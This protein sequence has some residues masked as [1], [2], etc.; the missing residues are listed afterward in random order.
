MNKKETN[1]ERPYNMVVHGFWERKICYRT[2]KE[3]FTIF[4]L[5]VQNSSSNRIFLRYEHIQTRN[6]KFSMRLV[7]NWYESGNDMYWK[8]N[9]SGCAVLLNIFRRVCSVNFNLRKAEIGFL[10][11][12][13][14][15][16]LCFL[17]KKWLHTTSF[18]HFFNSFALVCCFTHRVK[19][20]YWRLV[21]NKCEP[22]NI[23][24]F[25]N[26]PAIVSNYYRSIIN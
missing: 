15:K 13:C 2:F 20:R 22:R 4:L 3:T 8:R 25:V 12:Y 26:L 17:R 10:V 24:N 14:Q 9:V 7:R 5:L 6:Y 1:D 19:S 23:T 16:W 11:L 21:Q 18:N